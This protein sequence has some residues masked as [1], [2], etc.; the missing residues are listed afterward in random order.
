[1]E[2]KALGVRADPCLPD[3]GNR[4]EI[5]KRDDVV[6]ASAMGLALADAPMPFQ[7]LRLVL[8]DIDANDDPHGRGYCLLDQLRCHVGS[9]VDCHDG[10]G[11]F[12][13]CLW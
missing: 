13:F 2:E 5:P 4:A 11:Y 9:G 6:S 8:F 12:H 1:M 7:G 10:Y 3:C